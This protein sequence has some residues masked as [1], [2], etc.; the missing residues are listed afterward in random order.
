[1]AAPWQQLG[2]WVGCRTPLS[3]Q[4]GDWPFD[5]GARMVLKMMLALMI[6]Q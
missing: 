1:M 6:G 4:I 5:S 3:E 2:Q